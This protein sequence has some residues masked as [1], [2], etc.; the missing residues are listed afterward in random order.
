MGRPVP[1]RVRE[2]ISR[3]LKGHSVSAETRRKI[4]ER[5]R[6]VPPPPILCECGC[7]ETI[8][9]TPTAAGTSRKTRRFVN[10]SHA[11]R[12][13]KVSGEH[14][15][16]IS[17]TLT[18]RRASRATREKMSASHKGKKKPAAV[19]QAMAAAIK[20]GMNIRERAF[21]KRAEEEGWTVLRNGWPDFVLTR[22]D[23]VRVV[24]V[25]R[26]R[27]EG[28]QP[29]QQALHDALRRAGLTVEIHYADEE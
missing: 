17:K 29:H 16:K 9:R 21:K 1:L 5:L 7:G 11:W 23:A 22:G 15:R 10:P 26:R 6:G 13:R 2:K 12:G 28:L 3:T 20:N 24:E 25:K 4:S 14:R 19:R 8:A 27:S 18:G